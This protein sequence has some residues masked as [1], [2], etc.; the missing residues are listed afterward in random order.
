MEIRVKRIKSNKNETLGEFYID[1][2]FQCYTLEDE[3]RAVKVKGETRIPAGRYEIKL[4]TVGGTHLRYAKRFSAI[5]KGMLWLQNVPGFE[6][7]LIHVGNT[8]ADTDGCI[9]LGLSVFEK[10]K[11]IT[12]GNSADAY[13]KVYPQVAAELVA[14]KQVFITIEDE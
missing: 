1:N 14:G 9:L 2:V 6:Y 10:G 13:R 4:R 7:I 5:H 11:K 3:R 12:I 8:D